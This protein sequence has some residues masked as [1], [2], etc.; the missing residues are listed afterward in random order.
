MVASTRRDL[1]RGVAVTGAPFMGQPPESEPDLRQQFFLGCGDGDKVLPNVK[2]SVAALRKLKLPV[3]FLE[4][5]GL[6]AKYPPNDV[7]EEIGRWVD[8]MDRI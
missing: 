3:T 7:I 6:G 5:K 1:I 2:A 4:I 8:S